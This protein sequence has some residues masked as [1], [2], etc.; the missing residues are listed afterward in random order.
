MSQLKY[1]SF[2]LLIA[3]VGVLASLGGNVHVR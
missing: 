2:P 3:A 1:R